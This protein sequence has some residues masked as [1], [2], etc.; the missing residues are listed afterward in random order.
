MNNVFI[1]NIIV[2]KNSDIYVLDLISWYILL[3]G[4]EFM[5]KMI[6]DIE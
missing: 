3:G 5:L 6:E 1:K 2:G 4:V